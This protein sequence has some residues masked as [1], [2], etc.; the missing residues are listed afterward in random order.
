MNT[1][2]VI[3]IKEKS[4]SF[5]DTV[6]A[7]GGIDVSFCYQ[8]GKCA[9]GCPLVHEMDLTPTQLIHAVQLGLKDTVYNSKTMWLCASCLTCSTRCPQKVDIAEVMDTVKI[10]IQREKK[11]ATVPSVLKFSKSFI[12]NLKLFGR[13]Y[14]LGMIA[15]LKLRTLNFT[16][17]LAMGIKM[18]KKH[19]FNLFPGI[20]GSREVRK[21]LSQVRKQE[22]A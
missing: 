13:L 4:F 11:K 15:E 22:K 7:V 18:L 16:Q 1:D 6:A 5:T 20:S 19:K 12:D 14:E 8:C 9:T 17:D 10:L 2:E 21:I 3:Q